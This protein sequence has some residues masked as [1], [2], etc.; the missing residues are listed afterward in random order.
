MPVDRCYLVWR[1]A[2]V[3]PITI[4]SFSLHA[5]LL[6]RD[7]LHASSSVDLTLTC[8]HAKDLWAGVD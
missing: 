1:L 3:C 4:P 7:A 5:A 6:L 8:F 2:V